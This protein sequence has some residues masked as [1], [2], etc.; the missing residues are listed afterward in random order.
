MEAR[1]ALCRRARRLKAN[2]CLDL[3]MRCGHHHHVYVVELGN[4]M[5]YGAAKEME[6]EL[7]I[8]LREAG[9]GVSQ[10]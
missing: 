2:Q 8:A 7:A 10:A 1:D 9:Y 4:P 3:R 5:P 6:V